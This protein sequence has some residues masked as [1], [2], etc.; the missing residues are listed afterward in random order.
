MKIFKDNIEYQGDAEEL[1]RYFSLVEP[2]QAGFSQD[3]FQP[4][5]L[6]DIVDESKDLR[7]KLAQ[8]PS[9]NPYGGVIPSKENP[10]AEKTPTV[11]ADLDTGVDLVN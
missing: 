5:T 2:T 9:Y 8:D 7:T 6:E 1:S 4:S 3:D 10:D 11:S